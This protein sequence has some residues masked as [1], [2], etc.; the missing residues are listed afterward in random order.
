L[1]GPVLV[2]H[3][4]DDRL[5]PWEQGQRLAAASADSTFRLYNCGHGCWDP[6]HLPFWQ[7]AIPFLVNAGVLQ[8]APAGP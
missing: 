3:G 7:D 2:L 1:Q 8:R 6:E 4:R 5:I